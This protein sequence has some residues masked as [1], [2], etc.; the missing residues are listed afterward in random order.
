M[1]QRGEHLRF[2]LKARHA[3]VIGG[4][5]RRDD[6]EGDV[7]AKLGVARAIDFAHSANAERRENFVRAELGDCWE[8]HSRR[9]MQKRSAA[10][11]W[12]CYGVGALCLRRCRSRNASDAV[13]SV[14]HDE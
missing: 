13:K 8:R 4:E 1:I 9:I 7:A 14:I 10:R 11:L 2:T 12:E 3:F 5:L 6:F